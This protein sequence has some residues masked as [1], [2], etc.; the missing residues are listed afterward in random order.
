MRL[1]FLGTGTS[2]GIPVIGCRCSVCTSDDSRNRR[3]RHGLALESDG[4]VLLVD[5]PPELRLQ[6]LAAGIDRV[7]AVFLTHMHADHVHGID[8]LRIFTVRDRG[9]LSMFVA[10]EHA[11]ELRAR[12]AYIFDERIKPSPG[13]TAPRIA[14]QTFQAGQAIEVAGFALRT[15][16]FPHGNTRSYGFRVGALGVIVDGKTVPAAERAALKGVEVLVINSLWWGNPHPTHFNVEEA[17]ATARDLGAGRTYLTH[18]THRLDIADLEARLPA[19]IRPAYD[20]LVVD[21]GS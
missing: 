14:L 11:A 2:F 8:D 4:R 21:I 20:G 9:P 12:F 10:T 3:T 6:L 17:V 13:T 5:T 18:L 19:D 15:L 7:D 16:A 1:R